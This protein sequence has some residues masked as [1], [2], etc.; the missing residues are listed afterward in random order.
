MKTKR[1]FLI[2]V[3]KYK[4]DDENIIKE[5]SGKREVGDLKA[6]MDKAIL[7]IE[8]EDNVIA[9]YTLDT[10]PIRDPVKLPEFSGKVGED[11]TCS[12]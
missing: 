12:K 5:R 3:D 4:L 11:S 6:D 7:T 1:E 9:L 2:L 10:K 8:N